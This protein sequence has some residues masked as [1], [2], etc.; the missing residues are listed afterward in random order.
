M[1]SLNDQM[2]WDSTA[3]WNNDVE[4][5]DTLAFINVDTPVLRVEAGPGT[6][7]T[8]GLIRRVQRIVHPDGL[9]VSGSDVH[10]LSLSS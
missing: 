1:T 7:K 10:P 2:V 6:G 5:T 4:G 9:N 8:F 3:P